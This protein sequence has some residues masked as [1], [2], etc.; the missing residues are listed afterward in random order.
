M[1]KLAAN[2]TM[3]FNEVTF[4][5]RFALAAQTGFRA[6]EFMFPYDDPVEAVKDAIERNNLELALF[7]LP[8]GNWAAGDRGIAAQP[9]R[10]DE[11][12][13]GVVRALEY[14]VVLE[15]PHINCLAGKR[16][17]TGEYRDTLVQNVRHAADALRATNTT[18][19]VEP[20]NNL[21][22]EGFAISTTGEGLDLLDDVARE[23]TGLQ[24]DVYHAMRMG[25]DPIEQ[26]RSHSDRITHIQVADV[27]GRHQ[28]GTG[29]IDFA[30]LFE[31]IDDVGYD[32]WI[33]LEYNP[34]GPTVDGFGLVRDM[35]LLETMEILPWP[36]H[37]P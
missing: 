10:Q 13:A 4:L 28:P 19:L 30:A 33:G 27:P 37:Q 6:V 18:L 36:I 26:I 21:D 9:S 17:G 35:G 32:G 15:P 16:V 23:N 31:A 11:F 12:E 29:E 22:I 8:A 14:A 2:L 20:V 24:F 25:E 1:V 3:L 34:E 7:N 5:E